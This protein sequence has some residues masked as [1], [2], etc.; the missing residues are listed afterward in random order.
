LA[1][2]EPDRVRLIDAG[3]P[4]REVEAEIGRVVD[5]RLRKGR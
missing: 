4:L 2:R 1:R 5:E 3:R